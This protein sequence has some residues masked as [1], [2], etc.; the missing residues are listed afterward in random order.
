MPSPEPLE[1]NYLTPESQWDHSIIWPFVLKALSS[2]PPQGAILDVGCGNGAILSLVRSLGAWKLTGVESS[3]SAVSIARSRG[4][5]VRLGD[6]TAD[7]LALFPPRSFDL[8]LCIEVIEHV[9]NPRGLL[10]QVHTLLRS[11]GRLLLTTPYHGY[12]KNL[13]IALLG[14]GDR[15]YNPLW[16]CGHI[17]FWSRRTLSAVLTETGYRDVQFYGAGRIP[18]LW[19]SMVLVASVP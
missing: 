7:L 12:W 15:H 17:K 10:R 1:Y 16:D 5:D 4:L 9:Y 3:R 8:I 6:A 2:V 13:A 18:W 14:R 11:K 19:K